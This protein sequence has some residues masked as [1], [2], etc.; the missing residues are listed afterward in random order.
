MRT[1]TA[2][3]L[4]LALVLPA[5]AGDAKPAASGY[6]PV[7]VY[8]P[9]REP[10]QDFKEA[11]A[12][13]KR[14]GRNVLVQVGGNWCSWCRALDKTF[15][16]TA[17][18]NELRESNYVFMKVNFS[19]ENKNE[20]FYEALKL[21]PPEGYPHIFVFDAEGKLIKSKNTEEL[22]LG[23][24]QKGYNVAALEDFLKEFAPKKQ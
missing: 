18:L 24:G 22:E 16:T 3:L 17:S 8:D 21:T 13:A 20:N 9:A 14:T 11:V 19:P 1:I 5:A 6:Q 10:Q 12:E 7:H 15:T 23:K 2:I 4:L